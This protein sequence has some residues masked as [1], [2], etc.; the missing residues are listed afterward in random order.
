MI[1]TPACLVAVCNEGEHPGE[2]GSCVVVNATT[3]TECDDGVFCTVDDFCEEGVCKGGGTN[4]CGTNPDP[5]DKVLC[6][7]GTQTCS[8]V[9][10]EDGDPCVP[11][12]LCQVNAT[13]NDGKCLGQEKDCFF[14]PAGECNNVACNSS[15]G[16]CEP[17]PDPSKDGQSCDQ[18]GDLCM[19]NKTCDAGDCVGGVP[20]DCTSFT[21]GCQNGVCN[22]ATG[23]CMGEAVAAGGM[24]LE[25]TDDCNVG[26]CDANGNCNSQPANNGADCNDF[27]SCTTGDTC[28][29]GV[30]T[31]SMVVGCSIYF[32]DTF[33]GGCPPGGWTLGGDWECGSPSNVGPSAAL[34]GASCIATT[35]DGDYSPSQAYD[36]TIAQ[37]PPVDLSTSV[38]PV[39]AFQAWVETEGSS[40]DGFNVK[41]STDN[42]ATFTQLTT[43]SPAYELTVNG[44]P[45]WGGD[46]SAEGW[47]PYSANLTAYVGQT[48][49]LQ[50]GFRSDSIIQDPGVYLDDVVVAEADAVPLLILTP[51]QSLPDALVNNA[52]AANLS[53]TGGTGSSVWS[54]VGGT[55]HGWMTINPST[56]QLGGTPGPANSGPVTVTVHVEEPSEPNNFDERTFSF[57]VVS[58]VFVQTFEGACPNGW[59]LSGDWECGVPTTTGP[60]TAFSGTQ[61]IGTQIDAS[62][63]NSQAWATTTATSPS[64]NLGGTSSPQLLMYVWI[65]TEGSVFD[66]ANL[67]VST[68]GGATFDLVN[69]VQP[70]YPLTIDG[71]PAWGGHQAA[72]G[73]QLYSADLSG[74]ANEPDV[75][76]QLAFRSDGSITYP[77][78][79]VDDVVI[80]D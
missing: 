3:G 20:K 80:V 41:I 78:F 55:N 73:W 13:C 68:D 11:D 53:K 58:A 66:G 34:S 10:A 15:T 27:N 70:A 44:Q 71:E 1:E 36:T 2:I 19:V 9:P 7:E 76:L 24:C 52:Y 16:N 42:G 37:T 22:A 31:G 28:G 49:I 45:A 29:G 65:D 75:Q 25:G 60:A 46:H 77:G 21:V 33:E 12:D 59:T 18:T 39:L 54:I 35:I 32:E 47:Q 6:D 51:E 79:Y 67:K 61:C 74:Y 4:D 40:F 50:F 38:Q 30:C 23:A 62:Y 56:G 26:I 43:V 69:A 64:I 8:T 17:T 14:A 72:S 48:V 57:D 5:C 63:S